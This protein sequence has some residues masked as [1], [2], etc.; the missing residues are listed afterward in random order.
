MNKTT[1]N[2]KAQLFYALLKKIPI[3]MRI[4]LLLLFVFTFQLQAEHIYSQDTKISLDMRNSTIEKVLQTIEEKS[5]Y[6]FLYNNKLIDVD[7]KVSVRVKNAAISA[8][9]EKLF[10]S[11]NVEFEVKGSQIILSPK[12]M[13]SQITAVAEVVQQQKKTITGT[14][15]DATGEPIIGANI[16][17]TGTTN[18]TVTDVDG[19]FSLSVEDNATIHISYIGYLEQDINTAGRVSFNITLVEDTKTLDELVVVG[20]GTQRKVNLTG[21]VTTVSQDIL[22]KRNATQTSQLLQGASSGITVTQS[23]GKPG[24]DG[25]S[26]LIRGSGTFSGAGNNPL[27]LIDGVPG[28]LNSV[29]PNDIESISILK[30]ASSAAIYGSRAAN[31]VILVTTKVGTDKLNVNYEF[32]V[33]QQKP[34]AL[35]KYVDSWTYAEMLNEARNNIGLGDHYTQDEIKKFKSQEAPYEYPNTKH[36]ENFFNSG[37]GLQTKHNLSLSGKDGRTQY[38]VSLGYLAQNGLIKKVDLD[39]YDIRLNLTSALKDN[40]T[41]SAKMYSNHSL[42][43]EP[44]QLSEGQNRDMGNIMRWATAIPATIPGKLPDGTYGTYMGFAVAEAALETDS[45]RKFKNSFF[46]TNMSLEWDIVKSLKWTNRVSYNWGYNRDDL[47]GAAYPW[48][49]PG[50]AETR[51]SKLT[52][53]SNTSSNLNLES[54]FDFNKI[55]NNNHNVH[56]LAGFSSITDYYENIGAFRENFPSTK[57]YVLDAASTENDDNWGGASTVK[58]LSFFGRAN[59]IYKEKYLVE[60]NLRYDGSSRFPKS[61][62][63][64]LFPSLSGGWIVSNEDFFNSSWIDFLKLRTSYGVLGNQQ[65][66]NYPYQKT[67]NLGQSYPYGSPEKL[68]PGIALTTLPFQD[69]S[70][71]SI[72]V[73]D[74]GLDVNLFDNKV[75]LSVEHYNRQT[76]GIL[77]NLTVS[78]VLGMDVSSQNAGEVQ[79]RGWDFQLNLR[80]SINKFSY[81]IQGNFSY[82]RNKV[83]SLAGVDYDISKGLFVGKPLGSI[84]GYKTDGLFVD[85]NDINNYATQN[86]TAAPGLIKYKDISGPDGTPDGIIDA[87]YDRTVIGNSI[88]K[89]TFGLNLQADYNNFDLFVQFQ[90]LAGYQKRIDGLR[91]A[92][93]NNGNIEQWHVDNRWTTE[94]PNKNAKY[95]RL[96]PLGSTPEPPFGPDSE[97]WLQDASF[98]RLKT[99]QL[100]Y[101]IPKQYLDKLSINRL[102]F[103][104]S[105]QNLFTFSHYV[106]GWDPEMSN[107]GY[108]G[109]SYYPITKMWL[110]GCNINF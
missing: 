89:Y 72:A 73:F 11:E 5:D 25:A 15:T 56:L 4:T 16:V 90:G 110:F 94:N 91:F 85:Q 76:T 103:Y 64:G 68:M 60:G 43:N 86:Y 52:V 32:Y 92:L 53:N 99:L 47:F 74:Q 42:R 21:S 105:G 10:K 36:L 51:V 58:L 1:I 3:A 100:G 48:T 66:G 84:Y 50:L 20:Y 88:P 61:G 23:S 108:A 67:L 79:N 12:E 59:Y 39:R 38:Y 65:I 77:Y 45:H 28:S 13:Y 97:Y 17:E 49:S 46:N 41:L 109:S 6:Y 104:V 78:S 96:T 106:E 95:P 101:S 8:V 107:E 55:F 29:S 35:P 22:T 69:I 40:L 102:R 14:I 70:W 81:E 2:Q 71:E 63:F 54:F 31:G 62:R 87:A 7:R 37:N 93:H 18:G 82:N 44:A 57:L 9:L 19:N 80:N 26:V 34:S 27:V 75:S 83:V 24:A 30:D 33:G 98:V